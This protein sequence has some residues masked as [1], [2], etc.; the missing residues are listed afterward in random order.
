MAKLM[1]ILVSATIAWM[2]FCGGRYYEQ[3]QKPSE[4]GAFIDQKLAEYERDKPKHKQTKRV[5]IFK[6]N[7]ELERQEAIGDI[8]GIK[9]E[10][11]ETQ[12]FTAR[13]D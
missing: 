1:I 9:G 8:W 10:L 3:S 2:L 4:L 7:N 11:H 6:Q 12:I 13:K 5:V